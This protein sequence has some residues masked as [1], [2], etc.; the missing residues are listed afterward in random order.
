MDT[1]LL[2]ARLILAAVFAVAGFAKLL[3]R[4]GSREGLEGFGVPPSLAKPGAILLP[5]VEIAVAVL[6]LPVGTAW[7]G[8]LAALLLL[9]AFVGGIAYNMS[10]GR[11]PDCHCFGQ[12]HSEPAGWS[13]LIRNAV[14]SAVAIFLLIPGPGDSGHSLVGWIGDLSAG[15]VVLGIVAIVALIAVAIEGWLLIHL[16]GQNG[17]VLLRL[18]ALDAIIAEG[19]AAL[20]DQGRVGA[21]PAAPAAG[22]PVGAPAPAFRLEGLHGET[23]T[24][25]AL[26]S[27]GKPVMLIFS[28]PT[29]G[30]CNALLPDVGKW[31]REHASR[32]TVALV[33]R[34]T[35]EANRAK[36]SEHGLSHVLLQKDREVSNAYK[37]HGTPTAVI[38]NADGTIGSAVSGGAEAIRTLLSKTTGTLPLAAVPTAPRQPSNGGNGAAPRPA[39]ASV[40][41]AAPAV[42]LP[43]LDGKTVNLSDGSGTSR[44]LVFWN[45]GCG[46]CRRMADDL[47]AWAAKPPKNAPEVILISTGTPEANRELGVPMT[48]LLDE[49]FNT[50]RA[51]GASGTPSAVLVDA[52]GKIASELAVGAP[53]VMA[54]ANG[55]DPKTASNGSAP[56]VKSA[57]KGDAAPEV[58]LADLDGNQFDLAEQK[59][60]K[61]MLLFW[62]PGCGFCRRMV[63]DVKAFEANPPKNAPKL[64]LV[65]TGTTES[66][67]EMGLSSTT[68]LDQGF[69]TGRA[70]GASGT[71]SAVLIDAKGKIASDVAVGAPAVMALAGVQSEKTSV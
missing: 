1:A 44:L 21:A 16:L 11:A 47:K 55:E 46:F 31:Q 69:N 57:K 53:G 30:P 49:G 26:R 12:L 20:P 29:C 15:E 8:G 4:N 70:F 66:N 40:G 7:Y 48:T 27:A 65:S 51:F 56:A 59:G 14:L 32:L 35:A 54:L 60:N 63:D 3:D 41:S 58:K 33:S 19:G 34:G 36:I 9:L 64:V 42:S 28:D 37:A 39:A 25:D 61:T 10:K 18:D 52:N 24:L 38:V 43:D 50:G 6:L 62:N 67:R 71:P 22:L 5:I 23:M 68:L 2:I 45:P 13:T 17:R